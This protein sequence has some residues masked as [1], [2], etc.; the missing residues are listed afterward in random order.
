MYFVEC[1]P[2]WRRGLLYQ[3]GSKWKR[4]PSHLSWCFSHSQALSNLRDIKDLLLFFSSHSSAVS[5]PSSIRTDGRWSQ[6]LFS[7]LFGAFCR[8]LLNFVLLTC[9][10]EFLLFVQRL[11]GWRWTQEV[12][13]GNKAR[14][15]KQRHAPEPSHHRRA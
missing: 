7:F 9:Q 14:S 1:P 5:D 3:T 10:R 8:C 11:R 12:P 2:S 6:S 13:R 15:A 4:Y